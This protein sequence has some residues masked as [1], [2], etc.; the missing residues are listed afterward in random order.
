MNL[1]VIKIVL[2]LIVKIFFQ[3]AHA[4]LVRFIAKNET[5]PSIQN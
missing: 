4:I 1:T 3:N 5:S 2:I